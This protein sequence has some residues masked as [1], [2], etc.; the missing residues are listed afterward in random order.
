MLK[1]FTDDGRPT[2]LLFLFL[3]LFLFFCGGYFI[4]AL[5]YG[6][7]IEDSLS[8]PASA[9][10]VQEV[11]SHAGTNPKAKQ[12]LAQFLKEHPKPTPRQLEN[13]QREMDEKVDAALRDE[14]VKKA[15]ENEK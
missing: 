4:L 6:D 3:C 2:G 5:F 14:L 10:E 15:V 8:G 9:K 11:I 12:M 13:I 7:A 1:F